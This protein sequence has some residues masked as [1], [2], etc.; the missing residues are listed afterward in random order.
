MYAAYGLTSY[1]ILLGATISEN[2]III[3]IFIIIMAE[4]ISFP[5]YYWV[6]RNCCLFSIQWEYCYQQQHNIYVGLSLS[7][8]Q[9]FISMRQMLTLKNWNMF[10][11]NTTDVTVKCFGFKQ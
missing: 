6:F 3:I 9:R 4:T 1:T 11:T 8:I 5:C 10:V 7:N 2:I